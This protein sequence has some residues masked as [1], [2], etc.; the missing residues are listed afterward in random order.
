MWRFWW[1]PPTPV[2]P[3]G[4]KLVVGLGNPGSKYAGTRHNVGYEVVD[5]LVRRTPVAAREKFHGQWYEL[6]VGDERVGLLKP[7]TWMNLS[8]K[9]LLAAR[10][11]YRVPHVNCLVICDDFQLGLGR[12]R[13][14]KEGSSGGQKGLDDILA[15]FGANDVPRLRMGVG[16]PPP[17]WDPKDHVLARFD[18]AEK[19]RMREAVERAATAVSDWIREGIEFCMNRYNA[20]VPPKPV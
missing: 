10:D 8:G 14:R 6:R 18:V 2:G 11:F 9:S 15:R 13:F 3:G 20:E 4:M 17:G 16:A 7:L 1:R 12:L 5:E 19:A